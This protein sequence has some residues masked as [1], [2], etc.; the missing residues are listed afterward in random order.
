MAYP[1]YSAPSAAEVDYQ[2]K[3]KLAEMLRQQSQEHLQGQMVSGHYVAPS[4]TQGLAKLL[5]AKNASDWEKQA[6]EQKAGMEAKSQES[7]AGVVKMLQD[8]NTTDDARNAALMSHA[9]QYGGQGIDAWLQAQ[10]AT[11]QARNAATAAENA[12]RKREQLENQ[13]TEANQFM[14][15]LFPG[16]KFM[17]TASNEDY[18][19]MPM[20]DDGT[21]VEALKI[22]TEAARQ[23]GFDDQ[24]IQ[25]ITAAAMRDPKF[26]SKLA[27]EEYKRLSKGR[28]EAKDVI[29]KERAMAQAMG[30]DVGD[31]LKQKMNKSGV[32]VQVNNYGEPKP[33]TLPSGE[34][35]MVRFS[36]DPNAAPIVTPFASSTTDTEQM[37]AGYASRMREAEKVI[38]AMGAKGNPTWGAVMAGGLAGEPGRAVVS[39]PEQQQ[40]RQAQEDWVRSKLRKESGA[41]IA[42][43]EMD[44]EIRTY[45]PMPW[46]KPETI[47]QKRKARETAMKA[48][49][50]TAG[51]AMR[52]VKPSASKPSVED[53]LKKY[54]GK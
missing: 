38:S 7:M 51:P 18:S 46:D 45:F 49:E 28:A 33:V 47:E 27:L 19:V 1:I 25:A 13:A 40:H 37:T 53:I 29:A 43:E 10:N 41:V 52:G 17:Q 30:M 26:A 9:Q 20:W 24:A 48:M 34:Q 31:Y 50:K 14:Q 44:R 16:A 54:G 4:W 35:A 12:R 22:N 21:P 8:P 32:N 36:K 3:L 42:E 11:T 2:R 6:I 15:T 5:Q 39:S 23:F